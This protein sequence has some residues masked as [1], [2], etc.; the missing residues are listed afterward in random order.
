M[1]EET[2]TKEEENRA[3]KI[4]IS[5]PIPISKTL[6]YLSSKIQLPEELL[7][8]P[9]KKTKEKKPK[10][11][12]GRPRKDLSSLSDSAFEILYVIAVFFQKLD[13][14]PH[15][16]EIA[17]VTNI[18]K[19]MVWHYCKILKMMNFIIIKYSCP[20]ITD[21]GFLYMKQRIEAE[22]LSEI[23]RIKFIKSIGAVPSDRL[24]AGKKKV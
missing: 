14:P 15:F 13:R 2:S 3:A 8:D 23:E 20:K 7:N 17:E 11:P 9:L 18:D 24:P 4:S 10:N 21:K 5:D 1:Q 6:E 12:R 22:R 19:K 16:N